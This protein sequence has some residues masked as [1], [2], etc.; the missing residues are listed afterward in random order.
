MD[1]ELE[2]A[3][4]D[5]A[6]TTEKSQRFSS[7]LFERFPWLCEKAA[8]TRSGTKSQVVQLAAARFS[9]LLANRQGARAMHLTRQAVG[10]M[11]KS[12]L[13][14]GYDVIR[15]ARHAYRLFLTAREIDPGLRS[16]LLGLVAMEEGP[17]FEIPESELRELAEALCK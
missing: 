13:E 2:T 14:Q 8:R 11:I 12:E 10:Q 15:I 17:Q 5:A 16:E 7:A 6:L 4:F 1:S 9:V 3:P